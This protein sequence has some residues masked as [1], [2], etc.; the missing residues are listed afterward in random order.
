MARIEREINN[1]EATVKEV[2]DMSEDARAALGLKPVFEYL[3]VARSV[4][5]PI[6]KLPVELLS[7]VFSYLI[8]SY[9]DRLQTP[10]DMTLEAGIFGDRYST[11]HR[12]AS[13]CKHWWR[14]MRDTPMLRPQA[15]LIPGSYSCKDLLAVRRY[16]EMVSPHPFKFCL[17]RDVHVCSDASTRQTEQTNYWAIVQALVK[18]SSLWRVAELHAPDRCGLDNVS[19][20]VAVFVYRSSYPVLKELC[21]YSCSTS[22]FFFPEQVPALR[23]LRLHACQIDLHAMQP[24]LRQIT[25]LNL[26]FLKD[27]DFHAVLSLAPALSQ[28]TVRGCTS[29]EVARA[30][31]VCDSHQ[32]SSNTVS[33]PQLRRLD[34][35]QSLFMLDIIT[36]PNLVHFCLYDSSPHLEV[37][38]FFLRRSRCN[39]ESLCVDKVGSSIALVELL[40]QMPYVTHLSV[41]AYLDVWLAL[42]ERN[43]DGGFT[44]LPRL[45]H[46]EVEIDKAEKPSFRNIHNVIRVA[47]KR[48]GARKI[49]VEGRVGYRKGKEP[50]ATLR[51]LDIR[52]PEARSQY[53]ELQALS[54][55]GALE[56]Y[57][58]ASD[59]TRFINTRYHDF[60]D[61]GESDDGDGEDGGDRDIAYI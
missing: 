44:V 31:I 58:V 3:A 8:A 13:V 52:C 28:L 12:L 50:H 5:S 9:S 21:L 40:R 18:V 16:I 33:L 45:Q 49:K 32:L 37:V 4:L 34:L 2:N 42:R 25:D 39:I 10:E 6:R 35:D 26:A 30:H 19:E 15:H 57:C 11:I 56:V 51:R 7:T 24:I 59:E 17:V 29:S 27:V 46:L 38:G 53:R 55:C 23:V 43:A 48:C 60:Y 20:A 22:Q 61:S 47:Q 14:I 41:R 54:E 1:L 36:A